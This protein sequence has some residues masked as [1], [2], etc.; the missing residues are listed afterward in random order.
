MRSGNVFEETMEHLL[1]LLRLGTFPPGAKLPAERELAESLRVSRT[2]LREVTSQLQ[3]AGFVSV[4][5]GRYGGTY[6]SHSPPAAGAGGRGALDPAQVEDLLTLRR[7]V[8]PAAAEL[9]ASRELGQEER[10]LLLAAARECA[11]AG[12]EQYR[13]FDA[14][15]HLTLA[16]LSGSPSLAAVV[17]DARDR[18][19]AMLDRIPLLAPNLA[20]ST[21]QHEA[22][23]AAVLRGRPEVARQAMLDHLSGTDALLRGFL[24]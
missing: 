16:E 19:N 8:E 7:I 4:R 3:Q 10:Q 11:G 2:T 17:A 6:V 5:R 22:V 9:A 14:R 18:V 20:H 12:L 23:V 24:A 15:L 1:R 21:R 13:P